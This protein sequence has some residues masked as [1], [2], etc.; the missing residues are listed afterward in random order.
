MTDPFPPSLPQALVFDFDGVIADT[1]PLHLQSFQAVL[2]GLG[3]SVTREEY[4]ER[5]LGYTDVEVFEFVATEHRVPLAPGGIDLLVAE[6][7]LRF[8]ALVTTAPVVFPG[9]VERVRE[10]AER[11]PAAIASGALREEI[12]LVLG[13]A[14][15]GGE[16]GTIVSANDDVPGKPSPEPYRLALRQLAAAVGDRAP[17]GGFDPARCVAV[18]DSRWG[19]ASARAAGLRVVGVTSSYSADQL[20]EAERVVASVRDLSPEFVSGLWKPA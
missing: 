9:V 3:L 19:V 20:I 17:R 5:Y 7:T 6:K 16:F 8:Q 18:E 12:E 11:V 13:A 14:G 2:A 4:L 10:W 15:L 1:E